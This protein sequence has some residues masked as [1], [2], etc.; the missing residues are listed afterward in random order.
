V[1]LDWTK[2]QLQ[3]FVFLGRFTKEQ[4]LSG[5]DLHRRLADGGINRPAVFPTAR[6]EPTKREAVAHKGFASLTERT[7]LDSLELGEVGALW[8]M[9]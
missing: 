1:I 6:D 3:E 8:K 4:R 9:R 2:V 5:F 7:L